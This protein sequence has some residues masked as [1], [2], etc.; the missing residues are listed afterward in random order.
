MYFRKLQI[1]FRI[2][3]RISLLTCLLFI[4][5]TPVAH[6]A[7]PVD[8]P[9]ASAPARAEGVLDEIQIAGSGL[10]ARGWVGAGDSANPVAG[11][12]IVVDGVE[13]YSGGFEKQPRPDVAQAKGRS[14]WLESGFLIQSPLNAPLPEGPRKFTATAVLK[15]GDSLDLRVPEESISVGPAMPATP[16]ANPPQLFGQL[17]EVVPEMTGCVDFIRINGKSISCGGWF[18]KSGGNGEG[19]KS[20]I[21][22]DNVGLELLLKNIIK[23][24]RKDVAQ[25]FN[26]PEWIN[27]GWSVEGSSEYLKLSQIDN[28]EVYALL[29]NNIEFKLQRSHSPEF[30]KY[31]VNFLT[32]TN[33]IFFIILPFFLI[34]LK[35]YVKR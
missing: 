26:K 9:P 18:A 16:A 31:S 27:S 1:H 10:K 14:D 11:I 13:I 5:L 22:R 20:I 29:Q 4:S 35:L 32:A 28:I 6:A 21:I 2:A 34:F 25:V 17:D 7:L 15:N 12:S 33:I 30:K 24:E 8:P 3:H 19:I 23:N